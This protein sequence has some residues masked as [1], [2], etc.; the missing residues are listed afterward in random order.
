MAPLTASYASALRSFDLNAW[1]LFTALQDKVVASAD[2]LLLD[3]EEKAL[4]PAVGIDDGHRSPTSEAERRLSSLSLASH[5]LPC[6]ASSTWILHTSES[7]RP[8]EILQGVSLLSQVDADA[9]L[10]RSPSEKHAMTIGRRLEQELAALAGEVEGAAVDMSR[11]ESYVFRRL[12]SFTQA[13]LALTALW[14]CTKLWG[15]VSESSTL[16]GLIACFA[17]QR[18]DSQLQQNSRN[19]HPAQRDGLGDAKADT[20]AHVAAILAAEAPLAAPLLPPPVEVRSAFTPPR[21]PVGDASH[22]SAAPLKAV[23]L[24]EATGHTPKQEI[25]GRAGEGALGD[26]SGHL[27]ASIG[28]DECDAWGCPLLPHPEM[29]YEGVSDVVDEVVRA[30]EDAEIVLLRCSNYSIPL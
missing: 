26:Y 29:W 20:A 15:T 28:V 27:R 11:V 3:L 22:S 14:M 7:R 16:S 30:V 23:R 21:T 1:L 5:Q 10:M 25:E 18:S 19:E 17:Q 6:A 9:L 13:V 8:L 4:R 12:G 24:E 2:R